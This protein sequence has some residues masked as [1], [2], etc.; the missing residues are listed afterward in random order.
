MSAYFEL[1][2]ESDESVAIYRT[3]DN[4]CYK[5]FHSN[6]EILYVEDGEISVTV[7]GERRLLTKNCVSIANSY[8]IHSYRTPSASSSLVIIIPV[9]LV[10][11]FSSLLRLKK[12]ASPFLAECPA[13]D[14]I[15]RAAIMLLQSASGSGHLIQ[16]GYS[17]VILGLL[18]KLIG[19]E[20]MPENTGVELSGKILKYLQQNF[21]EDVSL[22]SLA[23]HLGYNKNYI[24]RFFNANLGCSFKSYIQALR[25]DYAIQLLLGDSD[26]LLTEIASKSGFTNYRT[27]NRAFISVYNQPPS[28]YKKVLL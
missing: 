9:R 4:A 15:H 28:E 21:L 1:D 20:D 13:S 17:Y 7:N 25:I 19:L 18:A 26:L 27:F 10:G 5:H 2:R 24:S 11:S 6:I 3:K 23:K 12:M 22:E 16:K 8:E 14:E